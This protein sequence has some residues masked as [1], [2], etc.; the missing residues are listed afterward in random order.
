MT[1]E[2]ILIEDIDGLGVRG[3]TVRVAPGYA[4]NYLLP[5][6]KA[7]WRR[8]VGT[9]MLAQIERATVARDARERGNGEA[10]AKL[11]SGVTLAFER[12]VADEDKL[13]GSVSVQ[14]IHEALEAKNLTLAR[15]QILLA[16]PIKTLGDFEVMIRCYAEITATIKVRV[17]NANPEPAAEAATAHAD[18]PQD[19]DTE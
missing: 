3:A 1:Q 2:V 18:A 5:Y 8:D 12:Q 6:R 10:L 16:E 9:K 17:K 15:K 11:L 14:D 19:T 4:R 13:Y 7:I